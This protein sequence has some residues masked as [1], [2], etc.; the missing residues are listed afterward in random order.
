M[1]EKVEMYACP[2][3]KALHAKEVMADACCAV[4]RMLDVTDTA[5]L[6]KLAKDIV[7][8][9][10]TDGWFKDAE[11]WCYE[12]VMKAYYG[13]DIFGWLNRHREG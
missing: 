3:C 11:H 4:P 5:S 7:D 6:R 12:A 13:P 1:A 10:Y 2:K 9:V 8:T